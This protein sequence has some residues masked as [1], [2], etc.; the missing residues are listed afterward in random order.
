MRTVDAMN[1]KW[2]RAVMGALAAAALA[3]GCSDS[4][5]SA[6]EGSH[7]LS[8]G[9][10]AEERGTGGAGAETGDGEALGGELKQ[11]QGAPAQQQLSGEG[12]GAQRS[13]DDAKH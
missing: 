7:D 13:G 5:S 9:P 4:A 10:A 3:L 11:G 6:D 8:G 12:E 1:G 2:T